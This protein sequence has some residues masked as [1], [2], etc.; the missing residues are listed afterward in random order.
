MAALVPMTPPDTCETE[1]LRMSVSSAKLD[2]VASLAKV[3]LV[4]ATA[5][6]AVCRF[7][8]V[9]DAGLVEAMDARGA[10][11]SLTLTVTLGRVSV[12]G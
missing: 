8:S 4:S 5:T 1:T 7:A 2:A 3:A 10:S 12:R 6:V 9:R 11:S